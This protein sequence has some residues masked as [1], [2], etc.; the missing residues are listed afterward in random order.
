M[1]PNY[2]SDTSSKQ[3]ILVNIE[4]GEKIETRQKI[5]QFLYSDLPEPKVIGIDVS[6]KDYSGNKYVDSLFSANLKR[7]NIVSNCDLH[8]DGEICYCEGSNK[9][10]MTS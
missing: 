2:V 5:G 7:K 10:F 8:I 1:T 6:F 3:I 4:D 9:Y